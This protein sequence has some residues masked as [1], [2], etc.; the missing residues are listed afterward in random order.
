MNLPLFPVRHETGLYKIFSVFL[1]QC[2][3]NH[4]LSVYTPPPPPFPDPSFRFPASNG[5]LFGPG[6]N[7][8]EYPAILAEASGGGD[9]GRFAEK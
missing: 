1:E 5:R 6:D 2:S 8:K 7:L 3:Q 9:E 4:F